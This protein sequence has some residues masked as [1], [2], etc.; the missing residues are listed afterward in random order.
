MGANYKRLKFTEASGAAVELT[1]EGV[2]SEGLFMPDVSMPREL[3]AP[4][5]IAVAGVIGTAETI[6]FDYWDGAEWR[7][8]KQSGDQLTLDEDN[9]VLP[10][11]SGNIVLRA[12][13]SVTAAPVGVIVYW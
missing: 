13:K 10:P 1:K 5:T 7:A 9:T 4:V 2:S 11:I 8:Y 12:T 6:I 3:A